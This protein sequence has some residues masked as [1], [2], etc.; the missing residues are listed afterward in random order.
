MERVAHPGV[1]QV[2]EQ[3]LS[4][5]TGVAQIEDGSPDKNLVG[6]IEE[7]VFRVDVTRLLPC[8]QDHQQKKQGVQSQDRGKPGEI[9]YKRGTIK[10]GFL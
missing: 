2:A 7:L 10:A 5:E 8:H 9:F 4:H 6:L 1:I 3:E